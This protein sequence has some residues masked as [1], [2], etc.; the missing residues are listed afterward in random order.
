MS[1]EENEPKSTENAEEKEPVKASNKE[2][3][4]AVVTSHKGIAGLIELALRRF[5]IVVPVAIMLVLFCVGAL[6]LGVSCL[7]GVYLVFYTIDYTKSFPQIAHFFCISVAL[8]F[9]F[10][11]Y[12]FA[13][14]FV[15]P[16]V[17][18]LLRGKLKPWRGGYFSLEAI[19]WY[20]HNAL[21]YLMRF[22]FLHFITPMPFN[23]LFFRMMGM[24][25]GKGTQINST[26]ISDPSLIE[27]G[28][29]VTIGGSATVC[30]HYAAGGYLVI[31]PVKIGDKVTIGLKSTVM[32]DVE[33]GPGAKVLGNS[34]V[35][36]KTR[37]PAGELWGGV[38]AVCIRKA[39]ES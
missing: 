16:F 2:D 6:C 8:G 1:V 38:P 22:T 15:I 4:D 31:A 17:N 11:L 29:K 9:A 27:L 10:F 32:G 37:I 3:L 21:L 19:P 26:N 12:G 34:F 20:I 36:P 35:M 28:N 13:M 33:I 7:P 25:I 30:C 24:K 5:R 14:I 18:F 39:K 23:I